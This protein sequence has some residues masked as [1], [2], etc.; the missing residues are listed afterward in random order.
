LTRGGPDASLKWE[1]ATVRRGRIA[2]ST[3]SLG[4]REAAQYNARILRPL[5]EFVRCEYGATALAD[6]AAAGSLQANEL[7][8]RSI[9]ISIDRLEKVLVA[10]RA[11]MASD[12]AFK[13]ACV[14]RLAEAYGPIRYVMWATSPAAVYAAAGRTYKLVTTNGD[15]EILSNTRTSMHARL[16]RPIPISRLHCLLQQAQTAALPT[17]WG[18]PPALLREEG[19][20]ALGDDACVYRLQWFDVKRW[21]PLA[22]GLS[23][24]LA[25]AAALSSAHILTGAGAAAVT[26]LGLAVGSLYEQHHTGARNLRVGEEINLALKQLADEEAEARRELLELHQRQ[27]DWA[28]LLEDETRER[29]AAFQSAFDR[30]EELRRTRDT[31]LRGFSHDLNNPLSVLRAN[32]V[33]LKEKQLDPEVNEVID[34]FEQAATQ[35]GKLLGELMKA[36]TG[37]M[38]ARPVSPLRIEVA[39]ITDRLRRRIRALVYGRD[40]RTS[41]FRTR[42]APEAI[43]TDVLLFDRVVDNILTN[44]AKYTEIGS[45]IVEVDGTPSSL[46]I[47]VSDTGRG[48]APE[49][50]EQ[51]FQPG[52]AR[53][54]NG[55]GVGLSVV[56]ELLGQ[57]GGRLEVMSRPAHGTTFW[58]HFP[59][60]IPLQT[61]LPRP[62]GERRAEPYEQ[63]LGRVLTIRRLKSA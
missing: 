12:D 5:A 23:G 31:T 11:R 47:K 43:T 25:T 44:A 27:R 30:I 13:S 55:H 7:D 34:D 56:V 59:I 1:L 6:V 26:L 51:T 19:C 57:V 32:I 16:R 10:A 52:A 60:E 42:E 15:V 33:Y 54:P 21:L 48:I 24:G 37:S 49:D 17:I 20:V 22:A 18:L 50:L 39:A 46:V 38:A 14:F 63:T 58:V 41:V 2:L 45:I 9:W 35:I 8:G 29:T 36:V 40:I 62:E 53:G 4:P 3:S 28:R 61:D